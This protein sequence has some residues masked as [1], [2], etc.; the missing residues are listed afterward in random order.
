MCIRDRAAIVVVV[1]CSNSKRKS[2]FVGGV[3]LSPLDPWSDSRRHRA[4]RTR[5]VLGKLLKLSNV[6]QAIALPRL[7]AYGRGHSLPCCPLSNASETGDACI[8]N[9]RESQNRTDRQTAG[10][11]SIALVP[12]RKTWAY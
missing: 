3:C 5:I 11:Y 10:L 4:D 1:C 9:R 2:I 12:Y 6:K 8:P 7:I